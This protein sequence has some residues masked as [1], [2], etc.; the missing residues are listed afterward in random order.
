MSLCRISCAGSH[1]VDLVGL[2]LRDQPTSV[3]LPSDS[4][5]SVCH[6]AYPKLF[7]KARN[8]ISSMQGL[9]DNRIGRTTFAYIALILKPDKAITRKLQTNNLQTQWH[10]L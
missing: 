5:R 6:H 7:L 10:F 9:L 8:P 4:I 2:E 1:Y 3:F